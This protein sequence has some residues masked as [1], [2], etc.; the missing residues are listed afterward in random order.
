MC[1]GKCQLAFVVGFVEPTFEL[2][3]KLA[4][5]TAARCLQCLKDTHKFW[6]ANC[7][8]IPTADC[9]MRVTKAT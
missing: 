9:L 8:G 3:G 5:V 6:S 1:M 4:P 2:F 7:D